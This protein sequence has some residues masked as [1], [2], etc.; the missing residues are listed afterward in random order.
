MTIFIFLIGL[1]PAYI[2]YKLDIFRHADKFAM[3]GVAV[4]TVIAAFVTLV[5]RDVLG[6]DFLLRYSYVLT[7]LWI[8]LLLRFINSSKVLDPGTCDQ[9]M[10]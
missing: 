3:F 2:I 4:P 7:A 9:H 1:V 10:P 5:M 8:M 6:S